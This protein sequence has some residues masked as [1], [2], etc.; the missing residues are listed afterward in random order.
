VIDFSTF[1]LGACWHLAGLAAP[2]DVVVAMTDPPSLGIAVWPVAWLKR[3]RQLHWAQDIYPEVAMA[4][5]RRRLLHALGILLRPWRNLAW[6]QSAGCVAPG[7][8]MARF[9]AGTGVAP[10]KITVIPNWAPHG[11]APQSP[12]AAEPLRARWNL[13][14]KFVVAYSGNL[15][16]VHDL[17]PVLALAAA[18]RDEPR[19]AFVFIGSGAQRPGLEKA[20]AE[21]RLPNVHFQ[22]AQPRPELAMTLALGD[23]HLVT[24]RAGCERLVFPSKLYGIAAVGRPVVFIGPRDCELARLVVERAFGFAFTRDEVS[25][26]ADLL[27]Q[28]AADPARGTAL[29][30][31]AAEFSRAEGR[32]DHAVAA[33]E[34]LLR[35]AAC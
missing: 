28:L 30:H 12:A 29:G 5:S 1:L 7:G 19:I 17:E 18:V 4:L 20:T 21:R 32:L 16:R 35:E 27:R 3:T 8:D 15:G 34:R 14:G 23:V 33:W 22:S 26:M 13:Q 10:E 25:A 6:R 31:A 24:L 2:G 9:V 11:L